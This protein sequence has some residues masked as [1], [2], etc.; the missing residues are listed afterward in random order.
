MCN[1]SILNCFWF[2]FVSLAISR[3]AEP[4]V[5]W[6]ELDSS[7]PSCRVSFNRSSSRDTFPLK[8]AKF[9]SCSAFSS[10]STEI[11]AAASRRSIFISQNCLLLVLNSFKPVFTST[12]RAFCFLSA[13][14]LSYSKRDVAANTALWRF[15]FSSLLHTSWVDKRFNSSCISS[16]SR[17]FL[18]AQFLRLV[19]CS[20]CFSMMDAAISNSFF[21]SLRVVSMRVS[22]KL[23]SLFVCVNSSISLFLKHNL[24]SIVVRSEHFNRR[25]SFASTNPTSFSFK[26]FCVF[27]RSSS[28]CLTIVSSILTF[29]SLSPRHRLRWAFSHWISSSSR[30]MNEHSLALSC[31]QLLKYSTDSSLSFKSFLNFSTTLAV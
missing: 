13:K 14:N 17:V 30:R 5:N 26:Y 15:D 23:F 28:S 16:A 20:F 11:R 22:S 18:I 4:I 10:S 24:A 25:V 6:S 27:W 2:S 8:A 1:N 31:E 7:F 9:S 12:C 21:T 3:S 29:S 19:H